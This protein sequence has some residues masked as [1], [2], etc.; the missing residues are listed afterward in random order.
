MLDNVTLVQL[1]TFATVARV[2]NFTHAAE[3]LGYTPPAVHQQIGKLER[4]L[5]VLLVKR[6][7][8][9]M[10][11]TREGEAMLPVV[12]RVLDGLGELAQLS[13][14][15]QEDARVTVGGGRSTGVYVLP[16]ILQQYALVAPDA[17]VDYSVASAEELVERVLTGDLDVAVSS[18]IIGLIDRQE[19]ARRGLRLVPWM[20][21]RGGLF[22]LP[23]WKTAG[24][25]V[26]V[27][28]APYADLASTERGLRERFPFLQAHQWR[29]AALPST[30]AVKSALLNGLGLAFAT[31]DAFRAEVR[32]GAVVQEPSVGPDRFEWAY[33]LHRDNRLLSLEARSL[34]AFIASRRHDFSTHEALPP[35]PRKTPTPRKATEPRKAAA[36]R[37]P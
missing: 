30:D 32:T 12:V 25:P 8:V 18:R 6:D 3:V 7:Q 1:R 28:V 2:R 10:E 22:R 19:A 26:S 9:P 15:V 13:R 11:L 34:I 14:S 31:T 27:F 35:A 5:G 36:T 16:A 37:R 24:R 4:A 23:D 29:L 33:L 20:A 17:E 21:I